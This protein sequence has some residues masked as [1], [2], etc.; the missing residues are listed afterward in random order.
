[1]ALGNIIINVLSY[2]YFNRTIFDTM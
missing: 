1:M 2:Y